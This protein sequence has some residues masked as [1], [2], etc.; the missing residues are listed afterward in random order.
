MNS[1]TVWAVTVTLTTLLLAACG[2][3]SEAE[4]YSY[5]GLEFENQGNLQEAI[6]EYDEVIRLDPQYTPAYYNR[7]NAYL[8]LGQPQRAIE[9]F[10]EV[11]RLDSQFALPYALRA[12][13]ITLMGR[14][15][16]VQKDIERAVELGVDRGS[17]EAIIER[18]KSQR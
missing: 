14:D 5:A 13:A 1:Q 15:D 16:D 6:V 9:D 17:L 12:W 18:A 2:S 8:E 10:D 7:G 4:K 3:V 11:I